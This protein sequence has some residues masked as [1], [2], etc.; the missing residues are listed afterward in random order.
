MARS[1]AFRMSFWIWNFVAVMCAP[2]PDI[3]LSL[4]FFDSRPAATSRVFVPPIKCPMPTPCTS[5]NAVDPGVQTVLGRTLTFLRPSW[6]QPVAA[7]TGNVYHTY[8]EVGGAEP[9]LAPVDVDAAGS[10]AFQDAII[11]DAAW[12]VALRLAQSGNNQ[13]KD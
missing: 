13:A 9:N 11:G 6:S 10:N 7:R 4:P 12:E 8:L 5:S 1:N 2:S 3:R